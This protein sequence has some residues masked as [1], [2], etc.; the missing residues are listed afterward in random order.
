MAWYKAYQTLARHP[1][2]LRLARM[3]K[4][5]RRYAV[6]LLHDLFAWG[7]DAAGKHGEL[8][9]MEAEDIAAALDLSGKKGTATIQALVESGYLELHDGV[10]S[11]HDWY[12]YS[13]NLAERREKDRARKA[14]SVSGNAE[15]FRNHSSGIPAE[16]QAQRVEKSKS[17]VFTTI[18]DLPKGEPTTSTKSARARGYDPDFGEIMGVIMDRLNP[19]P[20]PIMIDDIKRFL[21]TLEPD[22]IIYAVNTAAGENKTSWSY[23]KGI[24]NRLAT[25]NLTT[26]TAVREAERQR[27]TRKEAKQDAGSAG[28]AESNAEADARWGIRYDA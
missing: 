12:D 22:V 8:S 5:D 19:N 25:S 11:I 9:G 21:H 17:R 24:L 28:I 2:T 15:E 20:T 23:V 3:L 13:G 14:K 26:M 1:K 6:G 10:Y 16:F 4:V 18:Q 27:L 7:L